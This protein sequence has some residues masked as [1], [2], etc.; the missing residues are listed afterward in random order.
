VRDSR[1]TKN[2]RRG[3]QS[4]EER[5]LNE[6]MRRWGERWDGMGRDEGARAEELIGD[7]HWKKYRMRTE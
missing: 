5:R 1:G 2:E 4:G 6:E 7:R 3:K